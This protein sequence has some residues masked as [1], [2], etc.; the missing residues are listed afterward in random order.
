M[1]FNIRTPY[2]LRFARRLAESALAKHWHERI[3]GSSR[4]GKCGSHRADRNLSLIS[5]GLLAMERLIAPVISNLLAS[6][7]RAPGAAS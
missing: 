2:G 7:W 6:R 3:T 4:A 5:H 1:R